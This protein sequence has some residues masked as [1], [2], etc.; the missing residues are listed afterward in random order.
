MLLRRI[1][2]HVKDQ[3]W[4][5]VGIDFVIVVVG[6]FIGLQ[7]A[8]WNAT[9]GEERRAEL[10]KVRL[11]DEFLKIEAY[12]ADNVHRVEGWQEGAERTSRE[13]LAGDLTATRD[14]L[15]LRLEGVDGWIQP[16]G[17]SATYTEIVSQGDMDLLRLPE[18]RA[19][20]LEFNTTAERHID[21]NLILFQSVGRDVDIIHRVSSLA[22]LPA[23]SRP[24]RFSEALQH[25]LASPD[26][27]LGIS[28]IARAR[29]ID[30][31]WH[32]FTLE[33][34]CS[35]LRALEQPCSHTVEAEDEGTN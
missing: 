30:L 23:N 24:E 12:T 15:H 3:N 2:Q 31:G 1:T 29:S 11:I 35:V 21:A 19:A 13:I 27:Y 33:S 32:R 9:L 34:A 7:V 25:E 16:S 18:L 22:A 4:F 8:N 14:D 5:A 17:T 20:L 6:V 26:L 28:S 10:L